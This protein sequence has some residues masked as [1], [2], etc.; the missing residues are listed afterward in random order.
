[1]DLSELIHGSFYVVTWICQSCC[2]CGFVA[3]CHMYF[4][5]FAKQNRADVWPGF[6]RLLMLLLW[7]KGVDWVRTLNAFGPLCLWKCFQVRYEWKY[8]FIPSGQMTGYQ[9]IIMKMYFL[10]LFCWPHNCS[11]YWADVGKFTIETL[12]P[13]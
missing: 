7:N 11:Q 8:M 1:M 5:P 6:Q 2:G 3:C 12:M 4:S 13:S 10:S 9:Y